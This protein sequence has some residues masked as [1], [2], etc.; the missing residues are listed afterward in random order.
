MTWFVFNSNRA[1]GRGLIYY[2]TVRESNLREHPK[3][4]QGSGVMTA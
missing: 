1:W 2:H 4:K 3:E